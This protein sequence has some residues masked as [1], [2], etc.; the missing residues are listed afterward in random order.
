MHVHENLVL[1]IAM[2]YLE[3]NSAY[4]EYN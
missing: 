4:S 1:S 3:G 2:F